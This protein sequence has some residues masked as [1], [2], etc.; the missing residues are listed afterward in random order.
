VNALDIPDRQTAPGPT[1]T[2][3]AL[4][5]PG[6]APRTSRRRRG[7]GLRSQLVSNA[8]L[9]AGL[10]IL[11]TGGL[12]AFLLAGS[13][14]IAATGPG[15]GREA[16]SEDAA[17]AGSALPV[18]AAAS[19]LDGFLA[20]RIAEART[21]ASTRAIVEAARAADPGHTPEAPAGPP[22]R[23]GGR[24]AAKGPHPWPGADSFLHRRLAESPWL[25]RAFLTD[26]N[27]FTVASTGP[28]GAAGRIGER[29]WQAAWKD[30]IDVDPVDY[31]EPAGPRRLGLA[32]RI[33]DPRG[34]APLGVLKA[35]LAIEPIG[36]MA[37]PAAPPVPA[38]GVESAALTRTPAEPEGAGR[39]RMVKASAGADDRNG[40][41]FRAGPGAGATGLLRAGGGPAS[42]ASNAGSFASAL[43]RLGLGRDSLRS[44]VA[45]IPDPAVL[46]AGIGDALADR[47]MQLAL[48]LG[49]IA[50]LSALFAAM[51]ANAAAR[52]YAAAIRA[53]TEMAERS[54]R[55][56]RARVAA[57]ET[58]REIARLGDAVD[59]LARRCNRVREPRPVGGAH[60]R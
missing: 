59:R 13:P 37:A 33:E 19:R 51:L 4:A 45:R 14:E 41:P 49:A 44:I 10:P 27:G 28:A 53:V 2:G 36:T 50:L 25:E 8:L 22:A 7:S 3:S 17:R 5:W 12:A 39:A 60:A 38:A 30:G 18:A 11:L 40:L 35:V 48:A 23:D 6:S 20:A 32:V 46:S 9:A 43:D 34:G 47:R 57:V 24:R 15:A 54:A 42:E 56:E 29:W 55:G 52:R 26:R 31:D 16:P 58:P 21:W 1:G